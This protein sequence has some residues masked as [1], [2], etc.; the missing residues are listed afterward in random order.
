[1][2][3]FDKLYDRAL[4]RKIG[5]RSGAS[6]ATRRRTPGGVRSLVADG[7]SQLRQTTRGLKSGLE[8]W[9]AIRYHGTVGEQRPLL[10]G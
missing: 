1:M 2:S 4:V 5:T 9:D 3:F 8:M 10:S 7:Q 6:V